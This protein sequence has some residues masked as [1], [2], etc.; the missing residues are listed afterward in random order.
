MKPV[1]VK[2]PLPM[3]VLTST[4]AA[5]NPLTRRECWASFVSVYE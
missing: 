5:V 2:M 4:Q 1:V 3:T